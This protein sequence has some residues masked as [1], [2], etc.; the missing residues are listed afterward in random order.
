MKKEDIKHIEE[1]RINQGNRCYPCKQLKKKS[2]VDLVIKLDDDNLIG[3]CEECF[4]IL[5]K[6]M[7]KDMKKYLKGLKNKF[8]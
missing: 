5:S 2:E 7:S 6:G 4:N 3:V 8:D 1:V